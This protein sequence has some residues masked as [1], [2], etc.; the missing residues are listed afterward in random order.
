[1][2]LQV[3]ATDDGVDMLA[4]FSGNLSFGQLVWEI[5]QVAVGPMIHIGIGRRGH[6]VIHCRLLLCPGVATEMGSDE[7][8]QRDFLQACLPGDGLIHIHSE[9]V[10]GVGTSMHVVMSTQQGVQEDHQ[11][12]QTLS[13]SG[14]DTTKVIGG[15]QVWYAVEE[16]L[17][18]V[19]AFHPGS[20]QDEEESSL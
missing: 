20:V 7:V 8:M 17:G 6:L 4:L 5:I 1:M 15:S 16:L 18:I 2:Q 11:L 3:F 19:V 9:L 10:W 12:G 13:V 14:Q